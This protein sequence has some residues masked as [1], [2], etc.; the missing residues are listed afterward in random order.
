MVGRG[1]LEGLREGFAIAGSCGFGGV[2]G[3]LVR[4]ISGFSEVTRLVS[5]SSGFVKF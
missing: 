4:G 2:M 5:Y 1:G 3:A